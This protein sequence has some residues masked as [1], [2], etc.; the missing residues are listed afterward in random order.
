MQKEV[1][2]QIKELT[3]LL[4]WLTSWEEDVL[5]AKSCRSWKGYDFS[6][7]DELRDENFIGS[8]P[9]S[10]LVYLTEKGIKTAKQLGK[11]YL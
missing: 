10:K 5:G 8:S 1:R 2:Q 4:L 7:L 9:K 3:L 6:F 11:K